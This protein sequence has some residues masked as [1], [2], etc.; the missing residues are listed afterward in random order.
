MCNSIPYKLFQLLSA[1]CKND[2]RNVAHVRPIENATVFGNIA[3]DR[4]TACIY[5][6]HVMHV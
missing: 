6:Y 3:T 5:A 2:A 4:R 1:S